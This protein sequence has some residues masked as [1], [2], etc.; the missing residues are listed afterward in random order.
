MNPKGLVHVVTR[1]K[2]VDLSQ[3]YGDSYVE[4][5]DGT[6]SIEPAGAYNV[7]AKNDKGDV[8]LTLPPNASGTVDGHTHN[9]DIVTEFG[10]AVSGEED[11]S[12]TGRIGIRQ[13]ANCFE[14]EQWGYSHQER[15][16]IPCGSDGCQYAGCAECA[17]TAQCTS[18]EGAQGAATS[19]CYTVKTD[20]P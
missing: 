5:R 12:V 11:K 14:L 8:E 3:V 13:L 9:G 2:D 15:S 20:S 6:I 16:G 17:G 4:D 19:T 10:L 1:S 7:E 18:L